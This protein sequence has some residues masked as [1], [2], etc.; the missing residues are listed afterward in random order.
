[1]YLKIGQKFIRYQESDQ[2]VIATIS[3]FDKLCVYYFI[4]GEK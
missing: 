4:D 1:M 2:S 3:R